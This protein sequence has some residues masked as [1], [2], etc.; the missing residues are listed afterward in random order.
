[1]SNAQFPLAPGFNATNIT[2]LKE[3]GDR[4]KWAFLSDY[5]GK[6][7]WN[8][9]EVYKAND[10]WNPGKGI[11]FGAEEVPAVVQKLGTFAKPSSV[12]TKRKG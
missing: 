6:M 4:Q 12:A 10:V 5:K 2:V 11:S 1:M 9:R 3:G 7:L 8:I